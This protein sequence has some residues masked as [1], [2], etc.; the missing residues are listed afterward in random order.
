M[1]LTDL[2]NDVLGLQKDTW[3]RK[4]NRPPQRV[5]KTSNIRGMPSPIALSQKYRHE[6]LRRISKA[7]AADLSRN[8]RASAKVLPRPRPTRRPA[9]TEPSQGLGRRPERFWYALKRALLR[10]SRRD[11]TRNRLLRSFRRFG[12]GAKEAQTRDSAGRPIRN[13]EVSED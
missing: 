5:H 13:I 4:T 3:E 10:L 2:V 12:G 9:T 1:S 8:F 11:P 7:A 6:G